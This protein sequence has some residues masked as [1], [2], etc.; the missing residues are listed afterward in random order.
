MGNYESVRVGAS[1]EFEVEVADQDSIGKMDAILEAAMK[2]DLDEAI[3]LLP[4]GSASYIL[5]WGAENA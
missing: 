3:A 4:K 2:A 5:S 1:V